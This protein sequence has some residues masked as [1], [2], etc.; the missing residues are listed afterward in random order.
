[1]PRICRY[2][3]QTKENHLNYDN[4]GEIITYALCD[5]RSKP[6]V[7]TF[8][9]SLD[10]EPEVTKPTMKKYN[11]LTKV[12]ESTIVYSRLTLK[13][14][15]VEIDFSDEE[16]DAISELPVGGELVHPTNNVMTKITVVRVE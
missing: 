1:M 2:C 13:G 12:E 3:R 8:W 4:G 5:R 9:W 7:E 16:T 15:L 6:G 11:I 10:D 14:V